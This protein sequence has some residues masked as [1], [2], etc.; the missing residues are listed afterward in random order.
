[1]GR[2]WVNLREQ[3]LR[4]LVHNIIT[5]KSSKMEVHVPRQTLLVIKVKSMQDAFALARTQPK[6]CII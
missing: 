4:L 6:D 2:V 3:T 1:M 5:C